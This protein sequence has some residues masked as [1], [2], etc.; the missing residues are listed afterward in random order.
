MSLSATHQFR[1]KSMGNVPMI[2]YSASRKILEYA[3]DIRL[4]IA[5]SPE[6]FWKQIKL[7]AHP[8]RVNSRVNPA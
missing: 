1:Y 4:N 6:R 2:R 8:A 3:E 5:P 7:P